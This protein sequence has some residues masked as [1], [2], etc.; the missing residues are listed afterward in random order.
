MKYI[1]LLCGVLT[2]Y[3]HAQTTDSFA[4]V[5]LNRVNDFRDSLHLPRVALAKTLSAGC[6]NHARYLVLN[7]NNKKTEGLLAHKEFAELPGYSKS[8]EAAGSHAVIGYPVDPKTIV[9][10]LLGTF[11]HRMPFMLP[12]LAEIGFGCYKD[13]D[14]YIA[15]IDCTTNVVQGRSDAE[16][17]VYP[18]NGQKNVPLK[19]TEELP[20]PVDHSLG[21]GSSGFPVTFFFAVF[22]SVTNVSF[23]LID[24]TGNEVSCSVSSPEKPATS[25]SQWQT[26]CAIPATRLQ[27][28]TR[29]TA[30]LSCT[31]SDKPYKSDVVFTTVPE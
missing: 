17:V 24:D 19:M 4:L 12:N 22:Q 29:Y 10:E 3:V 9:P 23:R 26:V 11:Y 28:A 27:P 15:V 30:T 25:F 1:W 13:T 21:E 31:V 6:R 7:H 5:A 20:D 14:W 2:G 16:V 8:G 18:Y